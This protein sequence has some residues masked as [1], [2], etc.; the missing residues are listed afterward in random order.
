MDGSQ[1]Q[2]RLELSREELLLAI[3]S[4]PDEALLEPGAAGDW[5]VRDVLGHLTNWEAELVTAL[6]RLKRGQKPDHLLAAMS[7]RDAYNAGRATEVQQ[8]DLDQVFTDF[9]NVRIQLEEWLVE[10]GD[11]DLSNPARYPALAGRPLWQVIAENS[12]EH[13]AEHTADLAAFA[14]LWEAEQTGRDVIWLST[15][16]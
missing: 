10:F 15:G 11:R 5:S 13:E 4:L 9:Q 16:V 14:A 3:E 2:E 7:D 6:L 8:R 1:I 12:F